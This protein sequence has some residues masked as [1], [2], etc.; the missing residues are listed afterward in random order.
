MLCLYFVD[1]KTLLTGLLGVSS[2]LVVGAAV[3]CSPENGYDECYAYGDYAKLQV[4][5]QADN[6][7]RFE[8]SSNFATRL[9]DCFELFDGVHW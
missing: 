7:T 9:E 1:G 4:I 6:C 3:D 2:P 5:F 8:W